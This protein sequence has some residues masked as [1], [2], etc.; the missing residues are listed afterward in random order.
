[1]Q[2]TEKEKCVKLEEIKEISSSRSKYFNEEGM[3]V[4]NVT[5]HRSMIKA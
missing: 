3:I 2:E 1:M 4:S 5:D